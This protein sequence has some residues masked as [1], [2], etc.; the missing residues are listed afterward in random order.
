VSETCGLGL[1]LVTCGFGL[2][3]DDFRIRG[4]R[5]GLG[6]ATRYLTTSLIAGIHSLYVTDVQVNVQ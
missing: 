1:E 6:L 3:I 2:G 4:L 5:L